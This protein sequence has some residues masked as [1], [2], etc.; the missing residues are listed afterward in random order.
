MK[1]STSDTLVDKIGF[2]ILKHNHTIS[3]DKTP[4]LS[5][6]TLIFLQ[7]DRWKVPG[8]WIYHFNFKFWCLSF[9]LSIPCL[10]LL[11]AWIRPHFSQHC[12]AVT[13]ISSEKLLVSFISYHFNI[14][15]FIFLHAS[16]TQ[17]IF[18]NFFLQMIF[19]HLDCYSI[20]FLSPSFQTSL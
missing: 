8:P 17:I 3:L 6:Q 9:I 15:L 10:D 1:H 7:W 4:M 20:L 12:M 19:P 14:I 16:Q 13:I 11:V 5:C 2:D 18:S